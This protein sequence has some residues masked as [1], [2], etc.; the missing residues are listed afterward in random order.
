MAFDVKGLYGNT[1]TFLK[2][3]VAELK[4]TTWPKWIE[5]RGTTTVV[6]IAVF[7]FAMFLYLVDI[8]LGFAYQRVIGLFR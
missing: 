1:V 2:E 4:R 8:G 5:V 7:I 3:V 6:I